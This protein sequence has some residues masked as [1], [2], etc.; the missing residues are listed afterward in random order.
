MNSR[1]ITGVEFLERMSVKS[2]CSAPSGAIKWEK[3]YSSIYGKLLKCFYTDDACP[4]FLHC[5]CKKSQA[6]RK[7][8]ARI[9]L[10]KIKEKE[11]CR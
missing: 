2:W 4:E 11:E 3:K 6:Q 5:V 10:K 7:K 8:V 1:V 9:L